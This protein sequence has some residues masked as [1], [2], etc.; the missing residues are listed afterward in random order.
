MQ[1]FGDAQLLHPDGTVGVEVRG[2]TVGEV[3]CVVGWV[4]GRAVGH[5]GEVAERG[6]GRNR[7][8]LSTQVASRAFEDLAIMSR[9]VGASRRT[10]GSLGRSERL[11]MV[12]KQPFL[13]AGRATDSI[14]NKDDAVGVHTERAEI[15]RLMMKG[16]E[17][18]AITLVAG[19][20]RLVPAD[21]SG[22]E[23]EQ[24]VAQSQVEATD[25]AA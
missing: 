2:P 18:Q 13:E 21:M 12:G 25:R 24:P 4:R 10:I 14:R 5:L 1:A 8:A 9:E 19:A 17:G 3:L 16:A 20:A 15:E 6:V 22:F 23:G 7:E 11:A